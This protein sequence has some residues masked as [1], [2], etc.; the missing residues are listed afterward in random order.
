[1]YDPKKYRRRSIR[2]KSYDYSQN[3][4]YFITI[5]INGQTCLLGEIVNEKMV[6]NP[7]GMMVQQVWDD[8]PIYYPGIAVDEFVTMPNHIHGIIVIESGGR[9]QEDQNCKKLPHALPDVVHCFK[10]M[11][12]KKYING[13]KENNWPRFNGNFWQ[14]NY[15]EHVIRNDLELNEVRRYINENPA[16][17]FFDKLYRE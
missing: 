14:R 17:W 11:T 9:P 7:A 3:G 10:S 5:C 8:I 15:Y 6:L 12:T 16:K 1:M 2:L 13:V 4:A